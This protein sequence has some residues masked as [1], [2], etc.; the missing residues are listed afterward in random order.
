MIAEIISIGDEL[1]VGQVVNTNAAWMAQQLNLAGVG[2][3]RIVA[4]ADTPREITAAL[5]EAMQRADVI[6][7][8]GGLGPTR[9]DIT[10]ASLC[11]FFDTRL[12]FNEVAYRQ[13][14]ELFKKRGWALSDR[15]REQAELPEACTPL[16]NPHGTASG[17]WFEKEGKVFVSM[18]GVPFEMQAIMEDAV[19]PRLA[20][21]GN[22][23]IVV[24]RTVMTQGIGESM[25]S[26]LIQAWEEGLPQHMKLAYLPQ[27]GIVRLR[28][29]GHGSD[30]NRLAEE[31]DRQIAGLQRLIPDH[32]Y[33]YDDITMEEAVGRLLKAKGRTVCTAESCT[34]GYIAHLIT[35]VPGSSEYYL[36]SVIAYS[37]AV[38]MKMVGVNEASLERY[39]AVSEEVVRE[40]AVGARERFRTDY[41]VAVSGIAGPDGGSEEKPVGTAWIGLASP[42]GVTA[43]KYMFG[44]HRGRNIRRA[45]LTALNILR[46]QLLS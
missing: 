16:L 35:S 34:G 44:E 31:L 22:N 10:K 43:G 38:K 30:R 18:P 23:R 6:L 40:M 1:L 12:V 2:V 9:D 26:D 37:N 33:G 11:E 25:L 42:E 4:V 8:T 14:G 32:I 27:P 7:V 41:A 29:T 3:S 5:H 20:A 15:H 19:L 24:H 13:I 36:G 17:M 21:R 28:L 45:A 39:G 46:L